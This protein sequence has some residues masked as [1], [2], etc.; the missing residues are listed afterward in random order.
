M[1]L[2]FY[3][4]EQLIDELM[5]RHDALVIVRMRRLNGNEDETLH[6]FRGGLNT[7]I[8]LCERGKDAMLAMARQGRRHETLDEGTL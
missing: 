4:D 5:K 1:E 7:A 6:D 3:T 8:G 2:D